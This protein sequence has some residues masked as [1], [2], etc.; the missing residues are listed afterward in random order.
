MR[1]EFDEKG[2][3]SRIRAA[4]L[5]GILAMAFNVEAAPP[6]SPAVDAV[7]AELEALK[8]EVEA[9]RAQVSGQGAQAASK[10][11]VAALQKEVSEVREATLRPPYEWD[12]STSFHFGGYAAVGYSS[13]RT[14]GRSFDQA[15][16]VPGFHFNYRDIAFAE[17]KLETAVAPDGE[18]E[19]KV[20]SANLNLAF[21]RFPGRFA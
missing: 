7:K 17:A 8:R 12:K 19:T 16:F 4:A 21:P 18:T 13:Q 15:V 11:E 20:E 9:L 10:K 5:V 14:G 2:G 6:A 3:C 1:Y